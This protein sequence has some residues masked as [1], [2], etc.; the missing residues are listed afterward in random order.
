MTPLF[1]KFLGLNWVLFFTVVGILIFGVT[2][3]YSASGFRE[4]EY[5]ANS[6]Y[7]QVIWIALGLGFYFAAALTDYRWV[8]WGAPIIYLAGIGALLALK[9]RGVEK[10][11]A[12]SWIEIGPLNFQ[13]SQLAILGGILCLAV[14]LGDLRRVH[15][16]FRFHSLRVLLCLAIVGVPMLMVLAEPDFGSASVWGPVLATMLLVGSIPYRYLIVMT[17]LTLIAVPLLYFFYLEPYQKSRTLHVHLF[18]L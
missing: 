15:R 17:L 1:R 14:V 13:P 6:W 18:P 5:L 16:I 11:G 3:V 2:A 12:K 10:S 9:V 8:R 7:R 4:N